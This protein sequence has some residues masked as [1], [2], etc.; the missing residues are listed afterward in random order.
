[1]NQTRA[2]S[3]TGV[4]A[5][6]D[7]PTVSVVMATYNRS[8]IL[9]YAI[10]SVRQGV[11]QD[12]ELI[13]V[14]DACTDDTEEVVAGFSDPRIRYIKLEQNFGEQSGPNNVGVAAARGHYIAFLNHDDLWLPT[15]LQ[16]GLARLQETGADLTFSQGLVVA[17]DGRHQLTGSMYRTPRP[18]SPEHFVPASLWIM[19]ATMVKRIGPWRAA[20]DLRTVPSQDWLHRAFRAG[21]KMVAHPKITAILIQSGARV[22]SYRERQQTEHELWFH[23]L[24]DPEA[25][26]DT[27]TP[28]HGQLWHDMQLSPS[29]NVAALGKS[30]LRRWMLKAGLWPPAIGQW[31]RYGRK[32]AFLRELRRRRGL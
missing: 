31:L 30:L 27:I 21:A 13:V 7:P 29:Y 22:N 23:R 32:G 15:H 12:F 1:M 19:N 2:V 18:Y 14:A 4:V 11:F 6:G 17:P 24:Y 20:R 16:N 10:E 25:I 3:G 8:N 26:L 5:G 28:L 9:A